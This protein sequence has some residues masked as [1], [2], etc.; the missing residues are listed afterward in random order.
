ML[1]FL[2]VELPSLEEDE[3]GSQDTQF[4]VD[5]EAGDCDDKADETP[6]VRDKALPEG[7]GGGGGFLRLG[8]HHSLKQ[9]M[10]NEQAEKLDV[11]MAISLQHIHSLSHNKGMA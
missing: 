2:Q 5:L 3:E 1:S 9:V 7:G 6:C 10:Q 8:L 4:P 11:M